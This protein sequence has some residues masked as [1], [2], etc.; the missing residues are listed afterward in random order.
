MNKHIQDKNF[1]NE[2]LL[3]FETCTKD[4]KNPINHY[5]DLKKT[6][7]DFITKNSNNYCILR[8][9]TMYGLRLNHQRHNPFSFFY[10][11]LINNEKITAVNDVYVNMLNVN[12]LIQSIE[13]VINKDLN[14]EFNLSG[15]NILNRYEFVNLLKELTNSKSQIVSTTSSKF[16]TLAKR[17]M[18]TSFDNSKMKKVLGVFPVNIEQDLR[19]LI[20]DSNISS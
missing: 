9:I 13:A 20:N 17:P 16:K 6:A 14:G 8:P 1:Q 11:K 10:E 12:N 7:D 4:L 18:N 19:E 3:D 15:E 2:L 5:G